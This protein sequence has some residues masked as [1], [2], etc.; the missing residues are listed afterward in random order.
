MRRWCDKNNKKLYGLANSGCLNCCSA[1]T[2]HD[3]LVAH[4]NEVAAKDNA[5]RFEGICHTY[6]KSKEKREQWLRLT[7]FI[8]PEDVEIYEPFF[9]GLKLATRVNKNPVAVIRAYA[10]GSFRGAITSILEP[11]HSGLFYPFVIENKKISEDFTLKA[12][13]CD[14]QCE[15]CGFCLNTLKKALTALE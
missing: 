14:K 11:D 2:F 10:S 15:D 5:Y 7:N 3:N 4:E 9:D 1:H 8:R 6:L 13:S 12:A